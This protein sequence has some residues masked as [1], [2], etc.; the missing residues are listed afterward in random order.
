PSETA[1]PVIVQSN[2]TYNF[3]ETPSGSTSLTNYSTTWECVNTLT[4]PDT[5]LASGTGASGTIQIPAIEGV[6]VLCTISNRQLVPA[7]TLDK[8]VVSVTDVN[9]NGITDVG[10]EILWEFA[11][12]NTGE[13][14]L[15]AVS[16]T[17]DTLATAGIGITC[18]PTSLAPTESVV[19][20]ANAPYV[21]TQ[22]DL[23]SGQVVN[24]AT[25]TGTPPG[26][27]A[28]TSA[29]DTT[30]TPADMQPALELTKTAGT[31]VDVNGNGDVDA[32]DTI[33]YTFTVTNTG[34]VTV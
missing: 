31:P 20:T 7:L 16:V 19:C 14:P 15:S 25:A 3:A 34:N 22:A 11:V 27:P 32:G 23:D 8:R 4:E 17:D 12:Q 10:D 2:Q 26:R 5:V 29:P 6:S 33:A 28:I 30:T 21:L 13:T 1:G 9:A 24:T 18:N